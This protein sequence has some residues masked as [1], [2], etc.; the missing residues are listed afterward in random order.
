M[1]KRIIAKRIGKRIAKGAARSAA[2]KAALKKAVIASAKARAKGGF[3]KRKLGIIKGIFPKLGST[4]TQRKAAIQRV[5][6]MGLK[7]N[8]TSRTKLGRVL[9]V[10]NRPSASQFK[11]KVGKALRKSTY[12]DRVLSSRAKYAQKST[13]NKVGQGATG[14]GISFGGGPY[15][16]N[17][18]DLTYGENV[19]RNLFRG[20]KVSTVALPVYVT[21][22]VKELKAR[23]EAMAN[24]N[25]KL[26]DNLSKELRKGLRGP[27]NKELL[28][29]QKTMPN[30]TYKEKL[31]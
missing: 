5:A 15:M 19:R 6:K 1:L 23:Q 3:G 22:K 14:Y 12:Y 30:F 4:A 9:L 8:P 31:T 18:Q 13:L 17:Y 24:Y 28:E 27:S 29:N 2:Q 26:I 20:L 16:R 21:S 7:R 25:Q 10:Q 11:G